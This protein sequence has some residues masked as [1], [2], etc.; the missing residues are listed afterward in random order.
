MSSQAL[1]S[2]PPPGRRERRKA[3][4]RARLL[5]S[6]RSLFG[7]LGYDATRPQD[8][9]RHADL[10]VG[11]FY[12]HFSDKRA[13]FLAF[14]DQAARELM[15]RVRLE[16]QQA[17]G[18]EDRLRL[19]LEAMLAYSDENPGV[20]SACFADAA[21]ISAGLLPGTSLRER[22]AQSLAQGL[23]AGMARGELHADFDADVIAA[24]IVG[25]VQHALGTA[26]RAHQRALL[27]NVTRFCARALVSGPVADR[28][29][30]R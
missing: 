2:P 29:S 24:G 1:S 20:L 18:F 27:D 28:R 25:F 8:I 5:D 16:I 13:A 7:E 14:T 11:T 19:S 22:L 9:A 4:T 30:T 26:G 10:A 3:E 6:A 15:D 12:V 21:V 23:R 17:E